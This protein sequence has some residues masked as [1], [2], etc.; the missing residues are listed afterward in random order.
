MSMFLGFVNGILSINYSNCLQSA[1][2]L[3]FDSVV[4]GGKR[5]NSNFIYVVKAHMCGNRNYWGFI[6]S[7]CVC[8]SCPFE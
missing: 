5:K 8:C 1:L 2:W 3:R 4:R 6:E 7:T